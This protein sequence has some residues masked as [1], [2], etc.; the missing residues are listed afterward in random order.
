MLVHEHA[1]AAGMRRLD[2]DV[3]VEIEGDDVSE[4]VI[5]AAAV[6]D[7]AFVHFNWRAS[8]RQPENDSRI[9]ANRGQENVRRAIR[10]SVVISERFPIHNRSPRKYVAAISKRSVRT[11]M[12]ASNPGASF[13]LRAATLR[14]RA[15][16]SVASGSTISSGR[17][18]SS[19]MFCTAQRIV[20]TLP[21]SVPSARRA[22]PSATAIS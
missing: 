11:T 3:F 1:V 21:A 17:P 19:T 20:R 12:S 15:G 16:T 14:M 10:E 9:A 13:P 18:A 7:D 4:T 8:G 22:A 2:A 5:L 6:G